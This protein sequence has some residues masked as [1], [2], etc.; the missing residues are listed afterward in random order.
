[1]KVLVADKLDNGALEGLRGLGCDL[2]IEPDL[3][4][5]T[6]PAAVA[7]HEPTALV[8]RS[9]KVRGPAIEAGAGNLRLIIRAGA[10]HDN[11]DS[12]AA[13]EHGIGVCNCPGM[14]A[15][16]VAELTMGH[17]ISLDR[18]LVDQTNQLRGGRWNKREFA[19]SRGMKGRELLVIGTGAIGFEVIK[20]AQVFE[21]NV[22][23]QSRSLSESRA[24][25]LGIG[26]IPYS[27]ESL[28]ENLP[29]F[30][31][32]SVHVAAVEHTIDMC[33][34]EF[35]ERI[36]PGALF[37]NTSRG[38]IVD[39]PALIDAA[40]SGKIRAALDVYKDQPSAKDT[41]WSPPLAACDGVYLSHH[42]GASTEQ[43]QLAVGEEVVRLVSVFQET[44]RFEHCV[45]GL[46][47][48]PHTV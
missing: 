22:T 1:M 21:M 46:E 45:N 28:L 2:I 39:E 27:R 48:S 16:A 14:N 4:I 5:E 26:W 42:N 7:S 20:R 10:G 44:G 31:A 24:R 8:V 25:A 3:D 18:R 40:M 38:T 17:L 11:I 29:R 35:F 47:R 36:Q 6:L 13:A 19:K 30:D 43:A 9:T 37:V 12:A 41:E 34:A 33:N 32:V 15:V 23:A